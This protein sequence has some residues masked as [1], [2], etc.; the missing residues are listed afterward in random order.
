MIGPAPIMTSL[1]MVGFSLSL[2]PAEEAFV[3]ALRA[4]VEPSFWP[5]M[6]PVFPNSDRVR[7]GIDESLQFASVAPCRAG[8]PPAGRFGRPD[9]RQTGFE[10]ARRETWRWPC[11]F[12]FRDA[13]QIIS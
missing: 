1:D 5:G 11:G 9:Q 3:D 12:N 10:C 2:L 8:N 4:P 13:A 6:A 7:A